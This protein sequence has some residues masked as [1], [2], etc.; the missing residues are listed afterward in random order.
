V[1]TAKLNSSFRAARRALILAR[2]NRAVA[3]G[4]L[5]EEEAAELKQELTQATLPGYKAAGRGFGFGG[6][7][8]RG[9]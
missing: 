5:D 3:K 1:T 6:G 7:N 8:H 2:I 9:R 4:D